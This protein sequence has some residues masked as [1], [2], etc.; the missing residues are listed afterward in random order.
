MPI[1]LLGPHSPKVA[2]SFEKAST[3]INTGAV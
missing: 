2:R 1:D 3:M